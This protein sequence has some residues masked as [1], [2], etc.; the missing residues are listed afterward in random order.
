MSRHSNR[1]SSLEWHRFL[2]RKSGVYVLEYKRAFRRLGGWVHWARHRRIRQLLERRQAHAGHTGLHTSCGNLRQHGARLR[3]PTAAHRIARSRQCLV[4]I[5]E[6]DLPPILRRT[7]HLVGAAGR[8]SEDLP[9]WPSLDLFRK[10]GIPGGQHDKPGR[11]DQPESPLVRLR[12]HTGRL[13]DI[14]PDDH[15]RRVQRGCV[16]PA[17]DGNLL[18]FDDY[19]GRFP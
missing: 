2:G 19:S 16:R 9:K 1:R 4:E 6:C 8:R 14:A 5:L 13:F 17:H 11:G 12:T 3:S 10:Y 18:Q 15:R 7:D